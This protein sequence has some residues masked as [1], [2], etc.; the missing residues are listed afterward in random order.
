VRT[1]PSRLVA[2]NGAWPGR[3]PAVGQA[4]A[5]GRLLDLTGDAMSKPEVAIESELPSACADEADELIDTEPDV[6]TT[7]PP[8][9]DVHGCAPGQ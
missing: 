9:T 8:Y 3:R 6:T 7:P 4:A 5:T 1:A 2:A